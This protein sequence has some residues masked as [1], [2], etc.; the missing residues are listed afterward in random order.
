MLKVRGRPPKIIPVEDLLEMRLARDSI[1][2]IA[3]R[4]G[5]DRDT[6]YIRVNRLKNSFLDD[7]LSG[8][9]EGKF[10]AKKYYDALFSDLRFGK[11]RVK[12]PKW[13]PDDLHVEFSDVAREFGE[14]A[15]AAHCRA[16]KANAQ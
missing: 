11:R 15:A 16:M 6:I 14:F 2:E 9:P 3:L 1:R 7:S 4:M 12:I 5:V 10:R 8:W 13:V